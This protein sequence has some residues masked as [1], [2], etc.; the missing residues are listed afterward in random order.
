MKTFTST[1]KFKMHISYF[2]ILPVVYKES[3]TFIQ[4]YTPTG[5]VGE[6]P[7]LHIF[8]NTCS[9]LYYL[10]FLFSHPSVCEV[11]SQYGFDPHFPTD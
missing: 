2:A 11:T 8:T 4:F 7:C 5:N 9:C 3:H 6:F 1:V 10:S